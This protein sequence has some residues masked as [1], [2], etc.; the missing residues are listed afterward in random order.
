MVGLRQVSVASWL[1]A[2]RA[3][4]FHKIAMFVS[5]EILD[6][7]KLS[8]VLERHGLLSKWNNEKRRF[9]DEN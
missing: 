3:K 6:E 9:S 7:Q 1:L 5:A 4:D 8:D 2:A